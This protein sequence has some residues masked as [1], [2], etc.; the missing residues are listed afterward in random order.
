MKK[1]FKNSAIVLVLIS[2][3]AVSCEKEK[4]A[5]ATAAAVAIPGFGFKTAYTL[6]GTNNQN[7]KAVENGGS[8]SVTKET[9]IRIEP[10]LPDVW[11]KC[12]G[13][14]TITIEGPWTND[15]YSAV[16][17]LKTGVINFIPKKKIWT[18]SS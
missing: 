9:F 12:N 17:D 10:V 15:D 11:K 5:P 2:F 14:W 6:A 3:F 1:L 7:T 8:V 13:T 4:V 18:N 16:K